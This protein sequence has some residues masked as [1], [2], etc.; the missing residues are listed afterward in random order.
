[1]TKRDQ[2][3]RLRERARVASENRAAFQSFGGT[4][5]LGV[6]GADGLVEVDPADLGN[7]SQ[8]GS[9]KRKTESQ[10]VDKEAKKRRADGERAMAKAHESTKAL[11]CTVDNDGED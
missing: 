11:A 10:V 4:R 7:L 1:M 6:P 8:K 5:G 2:A 9:W 3:E